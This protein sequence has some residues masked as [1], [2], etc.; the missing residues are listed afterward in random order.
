MHDLRTVEYPGAVMNDSDAEIRDQFEKVL[1]ARIVEA[2]TEPAEGSSSGS[3][4]HADSRKRQAVA[5][6]GSADEVNRFF[7]EQGWSDGLPIVPPT[8]EKVQEFLQYS[9][10]LP[11]EQVAV[12]PQANLRATPRNIAINAVITYTDKCTI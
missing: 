3:R 11:D 4:P 5:F 9:D 6:K 2:L 8:A 7:F 1:L 10:R 12:L